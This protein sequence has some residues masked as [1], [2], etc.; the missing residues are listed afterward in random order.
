MIRV[1]AAHFVAVQR[2]VGSSWFQSLRHS[3]SAVLTIPCCR[4]LPTPP[5]RNP[6]DKK[7]P[8]LIGHQGSALQDAF[9]T[10]NV[11]EAIREIRTKPKQRRN[12]VRPVLPTSFRTNSDGVGQISI[13]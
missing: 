1:C 8:S 13:G 9:N 3:R 5:I 2:V 11:Q 12:G 7:L 4:S 10:I 6:R